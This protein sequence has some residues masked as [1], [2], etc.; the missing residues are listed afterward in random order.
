MNH[1][2]IQCDPY[3]AGDD[4][5][6]LHEKYHVG[7]CRAATAAFALFFKQKR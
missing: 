3:H 5:T 2:D 6:Q 7:K 1:K 4:Q